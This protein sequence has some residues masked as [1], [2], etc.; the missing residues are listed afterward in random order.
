MTPYADAGEEMALVEVSKVIGFDVHDA[1][2][3]DGAVGDE[4]ARDEIPQP[5]GRERFDFVVVG[6]HRQNGGSKE[7]TPAPCIA[8]SSSASVSLAPCQR[9]RQYQTRGPWSHAPPPRRC[10]NQ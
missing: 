9:A 1:A 4:P 5:L 2:G 10:G 7:V 8:C 6:G 3:V